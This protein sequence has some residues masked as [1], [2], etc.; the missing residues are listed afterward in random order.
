MNETGDGATQIQQRVQ[1]DG[2]LGRA[3]WCPI[4]QTQAQVD[5]AGVQR[6]DVA[7]DVHIQAQ[8]LIGIELV[9]TANQN[10]REVSPDTPVAPLVGVC[11]RGATHRLAQ[12]HRV[13]L[14]G[15]GSQRGLD[16]AQGF[17]PGQ[18]RIGHDAKV[19]GAGQRRDLSVA[20]VTSDDAS[21]AGPGYKLHQL[22][23]KR[24]ANIHKKFPK[25]SI[26]GNYSQK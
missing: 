9:G 1:L 11:Q 4:K 15:V 13:E 20:G 18:L 19:L 14:G 3:K 7:R 8:W 12:S 17:A 2:R 16:V 25:K 21:K 22:G 24:L 5:G 26:W 6:I 10:G 23:E